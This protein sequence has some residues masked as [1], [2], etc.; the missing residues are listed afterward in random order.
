MMK[1]DVCRGKVIKKK[2]T[3]DLWIKG[4]LLIIENVPAEVCTKCGE[5]LF[6]PEVTRKI[7]RLAKLKLHPRKTMTV[8]IFSLKEIEAGV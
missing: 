8:P 1:C 6:S 4:R 7:Q 5:Q 3:F 2:V